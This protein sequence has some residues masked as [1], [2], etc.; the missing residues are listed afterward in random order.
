MRQRISVGVDFYVR[1][2]GKS[3]EIKQT[4]EIFHAKEQKEVRG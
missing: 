2:Q 3:G 1:Q 4:A